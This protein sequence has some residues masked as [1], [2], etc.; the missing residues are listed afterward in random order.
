M[1]LSPAV[2]STAEEVLAF[3]FGPEAEG[4][5]FASDA[6]FDALLAQRLG[7]L[8]DAAAEGHLDGWAEAGPRA[9]LALVILLDQVP[10]N[11]RRGGPEAFAQDARA[12]RGA[13]R[14]LEQ[15][16]DA[17]LGPAE[18]LFLY[19]PFEH[20]EDVADQDRSVGLIGRLGDPEW[21]DYA[22]RHRAVVARFG[23]FP[24]RNAALGRTSTPEEEAFL[25][26]P[27]AP[28]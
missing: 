13:A 19:L 23:R 2:A 18:R 7:A 10:R 26:G 9:A 16:A 15:G 8:A 3:W 27:G 5:W 4:R 17:G 25:A 28:F 6:A 14:A 20:S 11:L 21:L 1:T 24:H 12:R 22:V